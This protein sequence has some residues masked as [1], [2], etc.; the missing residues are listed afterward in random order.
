ML[1]R[2]GSGITLTLLLIGMLT[3]AFNIQPVK[4]WTG[5]VYIRADGSIDPPDAPITTYDNVTYTL[6]DNITSSA[7]G[8]VVERRNIIIDGAD[9]TLQG[10]NGRYGFTVSGV[11][12]ITIKNTNIKGFVFGIYLNS[13]FCNIIFRNKIINNNLGICLDSSSNNTISRNNITNNYQGIW[14][15]WSSNNNIISGNNVTAN[16]HLGVRLYR[17]S[18]NTLRNNTMTS[19]GYNFDVGGV[20][21]THFINDIDISNSINSKQV[22]YWI[23]K[24]NMTV[25]LNAGY[26]ALINS[27][28]ITV[29]N[30]ILANNGQGILMAYT[31]NSTIIENSVT[32]NEY[33][34][35]LYG[36]SNN[37]ISGNHITNNEDGIHLYSSSNNTISGNNIKNSGLGIRL[38]NSSNNT[39]GE[40]N[41]KNNSEGI[42]LSDNS[43]DNSISRNN[44]TNN[45][46]GIH[47]WGYSNNNTI[48]RNNVTANV[49]G[50]QI[51]S[52]SNNILRLNSIANNKHNFGVDGFSPSHFVNDVDAS[53]TV[54]GN[55]VYYLINQ[56]DLTINPS[57]FP[58]VGYLALINST[59]ITVENLNLESNL[60]GVLLAFTTRSTITKNNITNN[61][62]GIR[63]YES[64]NNTVS[65]SNITNNYYGIALS[66]LSSNNVIYHNNFVFNNYQAFAHPYGYTNIWDDGYPSGGN[67]WSD[68]S[69]V[70]I[71][72]GAG[73]DLPGSDG[74]GDTPY[75]IDADNQDRYP[76]MNPWGAGTPVASFTWTPSIPKTGDSMTFDA[77]SSTP[78]GGTITEYEWNFGDGEYAS[79][80]TVTHAYTNLGIYIV[81]LNVT[82]TEGLWNTKQKQI[83]VVQPHGPEAEVTATPDTAS[84]GESIKFD[85]SA[86][87]PGWNGT[88]DMPIAEYRW[89]FSD[90]N[91]TTTHTPI[92]YHSFSSSGNYYVTLTVYSPGAT[93]ETDATTHKVTVF[94]MPVGGYSVPIKGY[95]TEKPLTLYLALIGILTVSFTIAKRRKKQQN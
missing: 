65:G 22:Y 17:S 19:N 51:Y 48:S 25:P 20:T 93:P 68:Y 79:G 63:L 23:D 69:G 34:I 53:N 87:L 55:P 78:N 35:Y 12:N 80:Q 58:N 44:I 91:E 11:S 86:S 5:T 9:C 37:T 76:L 60:Q 70:D 39:I 90:G 47:L 31:V 4:A 59:N 42:G 45:D 6:T 10:S 2:M 72:S 33:G 81:T 92:V 95:T 75:V 40:N 27:T 30:L 1:K 84:T 83:Q 73:Q 62:Y 26:V 43:S 61:Y 67:Y 82:D 52:S 49:E 66:R 16:N 85:A 50:I 94:S 18:N 29:Q 88:H 89:G 64:S 32:N 8:I 7:D 24:Q 56:K 28:H 46:W 71:K 21:L 74:I 38:F 77:S 13:T 54:E 3:L 14:L 36:S 15:D 41:I 57:T